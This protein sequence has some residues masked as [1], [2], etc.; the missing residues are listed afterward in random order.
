MCCNE[1]KKGFAKLQTQLKCINIFNATVNDYAAAIKNSWLRGQRPPTFPR[2]HWWRSGELFNWN[3]SISPVACTLWSFLSK[4]NI[5]QF[6][7]RTLTVKSFYL[8]YKK[9]PV[10][11]VLLIIRIVPIHEWELQEVFLVFT[12]IYIFCKTT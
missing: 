2:T 3:W 7:L 11:Q 5:L 8:L 10:S 1:F 4:I 6:V 9:H 12:S